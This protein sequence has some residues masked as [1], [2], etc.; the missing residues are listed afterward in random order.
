MSIE[1][2][3]LRKTA[4]VISCLDRESADLL[5]DQM[6][7][8]EAERVRNAIFELDAIDPKEQRQVLDEFLQA[9]SCDWTP[10]R[11]RCTSCLQPRPEAARAA[12][13]LR[14][15]GTP[16]RVSSGKWRRKVWP[17]VLATE[18]PQTI[19]LVL[20]HLSPELSGKVLLQ[21]PPQLQPEI[22]RRLVELEETDP[23]IL[24]EIEESLRERL[25]Q[26]FALP[27]K[28]VAGLSAIQGILNAA[29]R[30]TGSQLYRN[31]VLPRPAIGSPTSAGNGSNLTTWN[32]STTPTC[33]NFSTPLSRAC[34][35]WPWLVRRRR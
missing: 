9:G 31:L 30:N 17:G 35:R 11:N 21:F 25:M 34:C 20:S 19:A 26:S 15:K 27:R 8:E 22:F 18:R 16:V 1:Q 2:D 10:R 28:R 7:A 13:E 14:R 12:I 6:S 32:A 23:V 5:L 3:G 33:R 29:D 24:S 4:I